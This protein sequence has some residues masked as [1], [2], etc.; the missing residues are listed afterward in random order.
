MTVRTIRRDDASLR[1]FDSGEGAALVFQHGLGGDEA[2]V[3]ENVPDLAGWRRLTLDCRAQGGSEA[4]SARPFSIAMFADDVLAAADAAG[5][6]RF[7]AGGISMG[8]A[9]ALRLAVRQPQRV[10]ALI[11][12]RPAWTFAAAPANMRPYGAVAADLAAAP[13]EDARAAFA[14]SQ[15]AATLAREAPD[16]LAS[17]LR[18]FDRPDTAL[19]TD[20]LGAIAADGPGVSAAE[21][22]A[23][24]VPTLVIGHGV[25]HAHPLASAQALAK[26]IPGARLIEIAPKA[27]DK[28]RHVAEFRAAVAGFLNEIGGGPDRLKPA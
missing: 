22:A 4:G 13:R 6:E 19:T 23:I 7:V 5:A 14:A 28:A 24:A 16:N 2:Q 1:L 18:F 25:D 15:T 17:L 21:A 12:A 10:R 8:A 9:I 3:R 20:L 26:A 11:L 27:T